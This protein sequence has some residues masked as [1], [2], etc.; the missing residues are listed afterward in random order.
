MAGLN[1][2]FF[3]ADDSTEPKAPTATVQAFKNTPEGDE[4]EL[5]D[6]VDLIAVPATEELFIQLRDL[7]LLRERVRDTGGMTQTIAL[8]AQAIMPEFINEERPV[9]FFT[10]LPSK[11]LLA[12]ALEDIGKE[13]KG[14]VQRMIEAISKFVQ[15]VI[16][17]IKAFFE[18]RQDDALTDF[19]EKTQEPKPQLIAWSKVAHDAEIE[20]PK[21]SGEEPAQDLNEVMRDD[22]TRKK[23]V[24]KI[25]D[26]LFIKLGEKRF[27]TF[28]FVGSSHSKTPEEFIDFARKSASVNRADAKALSAWI[29]EVNEE[30]NKFRHEEALFDVGNT[31][32]AAREI[33]SDILYMSDHGYYK[34]HFKFKGANQ[35][36]R[37]KLMPIAAGIQDAIRKINANDTSEEEVANLKVYQEAVATLQRMFQVYAEISSATDTFLKL[38][39]QYMSEGASMSAAP[40]V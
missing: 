14:T 38:R 18:K 33:M 40:E 26:K 22:E 25:A 12:A 37:N 39:K 19:S 10:K 5:R 36:F 28:L 20:V 30:V 34:E 9:A 31:A 21:A 1:D 3:L 8:E 4:P 7:Q 29:A 17:R 11:T 23:A 2:D 24:S 6:D 35:L 16:E 32:N 13:E 15:Q 27:K